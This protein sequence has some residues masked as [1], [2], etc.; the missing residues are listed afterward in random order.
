M[1]V[2]AQR[3]FKTPRLMGGGGAIKDFDISDLVRF[4]CSD[5]EGNVIINSAGTYIFTKNGDEIIITA[6]SS[7]DDNIKMRA[8]V[9]LNQNQ[10][11]KVRIDLMLNK[12]ADQRVRRSILSELAS[13]CHFL[14]QRFHNDGFIN[15][16]YEFI[17]LEALELGIRLDSQIKQ[18][19]A[20][21]LNIFGIHT[22]GWFRTPSMMGGGGG[23]PISQENYRTIIRHNSDSYEIISENSF[24]GVF[25]IFKLDSDGFK[26]YLT[27]QSIHNPSITVSAIIDFEQQLV[28]ISEQLTEM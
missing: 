17:L 18:A 3:W 21:E 28:E 15:K 11:N 27:A 22:L 14:E 26:L 8:E 4:Q 24:K 1:G 12:R 9:D 13:N 20:H 23:M 19:L 10:I 16:R 2:E 5:A 7:V 6:Q 25:G